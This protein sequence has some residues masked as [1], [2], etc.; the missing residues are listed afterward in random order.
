MTQEFGLPIPPYGHKRPGL[1]LSL[2]GFHP[3]EGV[4]STPSSRTYIAG[5]PNQKEQKDPRKPTPASVLF[6][7]DAQ[8]VPPLLGKRGPSPQWPRFLRASS[9]SIPGH[10]VH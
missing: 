4:H 3:H 5:G 2:S 10:P 1:S 6:P 9:P 8:S 7:S